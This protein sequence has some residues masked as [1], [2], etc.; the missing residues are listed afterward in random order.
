MSCIIML[1]RVLGHLESKLDESIKRNAE[2]HHHAIV[3][4]DVILMQLHSQ[5][6]DTTYQLKDKDKKINKLEA[7]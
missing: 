7:Q 3:M 2:V 4:L 6:I 1:T 5:I